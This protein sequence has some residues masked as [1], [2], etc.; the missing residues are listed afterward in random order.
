M[1]AAAE[2]NYA[3]GTINY[4]I[5]L[6]RGIRYNALGFVVFSTNHDNHDYIVPMSEECYRKHL[7]P[8]IRKHIAED[9]CIDLPVRV[10]RHHRG[11]VDFEGDLAEQ[12]NKAAEV[13]S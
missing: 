11:R 2:T 4:E 7:Y 12:N 3:D 8:Y 1:F 10:V 5:I 6:I 13:L 9:T